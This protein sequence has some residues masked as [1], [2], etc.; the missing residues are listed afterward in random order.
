MKKILS[1][2]MAVFLLGT[3]SSV[4]SE[5]FPNKIPSIGAPPYVYMIHSS[6]D[7]CYENNGIGAQPNGFDLQLEGC[8]QLPP[9]V[10]YQSYAFSGE[11]LIYDVVVRDCNGASDILS[12]KITVADNIEANCALQSSPTEDMSSQIPIGCGGSAQSG[13]DPDTDKYYHCALTVEPSWYGEK[14]VNIKGYDT[15]GLGSTMSIAQKWFFNP[16][17][18]IDVDVNDDMNYVWY[19]VPSGQSSLLPGQTTFSGNKLVITNLAE[20]GVDLWAF[21]GATDFTDSSSSGAMCPT[22]NVLEAETALDFRCKIGTFEDD[23]WHDMTNKINTQGCSPIKCYN[24]TPLLGT[25]GLNG[26]RYSLLYNGK[27]AECQFK[28]TLPTQCTGTFDQGMLQVV[29]KSI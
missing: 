27:S 24:L 26:M 25:N 8:L 20:G 23:N 29:V 14:S 9:E 7:I 21:I 16:A 13:F 18:V 2:I 4:I 15:S 5:E 19:E 1:A 10:R 6:Y 3:V 22:S 11:N 12:A 17:V 28:L